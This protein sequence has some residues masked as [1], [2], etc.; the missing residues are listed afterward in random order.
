[1]KRKKIE[2]ESFRELMEQRLT[3]EE[4][5]EIEREVVLEAQAFQALQDDVTHVVDDYMKE[6]NI[7]FNE[8]VER[9]GVSPAHIAKIKKGTANLTLASVARLCAVMG[10]TPRLV[11]KKLTSKSSRSKLKV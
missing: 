9:L 2:T 11:C 5:A 4:I 6:H 3:K 7:G 8:L 10:K 1:M